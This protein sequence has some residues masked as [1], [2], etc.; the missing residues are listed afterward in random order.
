MEKLSSIVEYIAHHAQTKPVQPAVADKDG[1]LSYGQFWQ[2]ICS[3]ADGL[4]KRKVARGT[5][6]VV[7]C[8]QNTVY[9][10]CEFAVQLLGAVFVPL[11][12]NAAESRIKEIC[13][14]TDAVL[15]IGKEPCGTT[16]F[17]DMR[18]AASLSAAPAPST[19]FPFPKKEDTAEILFSTGTTGKS[20][21]IVLTHE[22]DVALAE[23][24]LYG[25]EV[26]PDNIELI[27]MPLSHSH[28][29]RRTYANLVNG[30]AVVFADGVTLLKQV[31]SLMD[32]HRVTAMDLS[33]SM[34]TIIFKLSKD[35]LGDYAG[36][37]DYIQLGSAPLPEED[38]QHL[39][40]LLP[41]T[42]LYN[43][44]GS[45]ESG[46]ACLLNFNTDADRPHCIGKPARNARFMVVDEQ[47]HPICSSK[48]HTG[49]LASFGSMNMKGYFHAPELTA[50]VLTDGWLYTKDLGYI[51]DEG[52]V[53]M[54][55][56]QDDVINCGGIKIAPEEIESVVLTSP[57]IADC[58]CIPV[59]DP[60]T[61]QTPKLFI[62]PREPADFDRKA[63]K[64]FLSDALEAGKQ[65][66][67]IECIDKIPRTY[68]G[69][70]QRNKLRSPSA[71]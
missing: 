33:P 46:C 48:E 45:T 29:L 49:F 64:S 22:N 26:K 11:E 68:N 66:K 14:E 32:Q 42:R 2:C 16:P 5:C 20:K 35:R 36:Q 31:F 30:S 53:Y 23:N 39:R 65:P 44:Y 54:L 25:V 61:G 67:Y 8:T 34:L 9:M 52:Y 18:Q 10:I 59:P 43:F 6:V 70:I 24:V 71:D 7:S 3:L 38:K 41:D 1:A 17:L 60:L 12:K 4:A 50:S 63:F 13:Q 51:D 40:R 27:P 58:A 62:V 21:G 69:K 56:R 19:A 55:G 47:K 37:I 57:M 15:Y 28:G